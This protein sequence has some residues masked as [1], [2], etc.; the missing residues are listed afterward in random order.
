MALAK[1]FK[2]RFKN[3]VHYVS[4]SIFI[5]NKNFIKESPKKLITIMAIPFGIALHLYILY[6]TRK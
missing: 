1:N 3:A 4:S 6:K 2:D 5:K